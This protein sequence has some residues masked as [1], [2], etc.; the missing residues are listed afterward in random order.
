MYF[1][2]PEQRRC[3]CDLP[4]V[5]LDACAYSGDGEYAT[6]CSSICQF[7]PAK[8]IW[9]LFCSC[10]FLACLYLDETKKSSSPNGWFQQHVILLMSMALSH[11][12]LDGWLVSLF[13]FIW[14]ISNSK[15]ISTLNGIPLAVW[16]GVT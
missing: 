7:C 2:W 10:H 6:C 16:L 9:L 14:L 5:T 15:V 1:S 11:P 3:D 13:W 8:Q 4:M 12:N